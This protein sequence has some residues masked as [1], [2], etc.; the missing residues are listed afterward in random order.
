[1]IATKM[2]PAQIIEAQ[3]LAREWKPTMQRPLDNARATDAGGLHPQGLE[4]PLARS[5]VHGREAGQHIIGPLRRAEVVG[6]LYQRWP[7]LGVPA[8]CWRR[9]GRPLVRRILS[10]LAVA[11]SLKGPTVAQVAVVPRFGSVG[12][13]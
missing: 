6:A 4:L 11:R 10:T 5:E 8:P 1:M 7:S 2:T 13:L 9:L 3:K 12:R